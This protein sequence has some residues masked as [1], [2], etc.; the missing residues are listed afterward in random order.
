M[1]PRRQCWSEGGRTLEQEWAD[2]LGLDGATLI[3]LGP[4]AVRLCGLS[5]LS[6]LASHL[7]R[8]A[9]RKVDDSRTQRQLEFFVPKVI[10]VVVIA[11]GLQVAGMDVT[12]MAALLTTVGFTGAVI[13]TPLGQNIVAG[14][15]ASLDDVFEIGDA[16][17]IDGV[18]GTVLSRSL[19]R[20]ELARPD[21][22]TI[23]VPNAA[24]SEKTML[25][26]SRLGG[27]R[28]EVEV[29]LD[30]DPD[31]ALATTVMH[32][33]L[34]HVT[35]FA[36]DREPMVCFDSVG[37]DAK[38]FRVYAW[39]TDRTTEPMHRSMLLS[40]LVFALEDAGLSVGHTTNLSTHLPTVA[41]AS[42]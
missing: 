34:T 18:W 20:I 23:W 15:V 40:E 32:E 21:G 2:A 24:I 6:I 30:H 13:F 36:T 29:P 31:C 3:T 10:R 11:A 7:V 17:E 35:W 39:I 42:Y 1:L 26:Y 38:L 8:R 12:G 33:V 9:V 16:I 28:I 37:G 27:Y 22:T 4:I 25:N 41:S 19:L 14:I 5:L